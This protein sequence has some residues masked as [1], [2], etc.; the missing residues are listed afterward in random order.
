MPGDQHPPAGRPDDPGDGAQRGGLA[1]AVGTH[2]TDNLP[3]PH[4]KVEVCDRLELPVGF[5]QVFDLDYRRLV[6]VHIVKTVVAAGP[7]ARLLSY[8]YRTDAVGVNTCPGKRLLC[9][10][11]IATR[12][13]S[14][15]DSAA[16]NLTVWQWTVLGVG[17]FLSGLSKTGIAGAAVLTVAIFANVL[18][19]RESTGALLPLLL[20]GD[21]F[22][23]AFFRKHASWPHLWKLCPWV[24]VGVAAGYFA[25]DRISNAQ[26]QRMIG[27]I[28]LVIVA[29]SLWRRRHPDQANSSVPHSWW[30]A[31]ITGLL[32]GF[33]TMV[34]NA[35]GPVM[36]LYFL[37]IGLP[38]LAFVGTGAWFFMLVNAFKVPFSASLGLITSRSLLV[39]LVLLVPLL[40]G[41]LLGPVILKRINQKNFELMVLILTALATVRL[42]F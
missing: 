11:P 21:V 28:L 14:P 8:D 18:P 15:H 2:Q 40:P 3:R 31:A 12:S 33:T 32:A 39:D 41:A 10:K 19:A 29:L 30:F 13:G 4:G 23:V 24:A 36:I 16:M 17:A 6:G 38:K 1:G 34:A 37:A 20:C 35:A 5:G 27:A 25:L 7:H 42:I 9:Q 26:V 22:G